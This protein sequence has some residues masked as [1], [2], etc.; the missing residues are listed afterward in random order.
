MNNENPETNDQAAPEGE[1]SYTG[2]R[3]YNE[4]VKQHIANNDP[5]ELAKEAK[6]ALEGDEREELEDAERRGKR[7]PAPK[8]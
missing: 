2:T 5:E 1:G 7:G 8:P 4:H 3:R 6:R